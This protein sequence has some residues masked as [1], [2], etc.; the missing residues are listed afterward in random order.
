[1]KRKTAII[2]CSYLVIAA[3]ML[4]LFAS[5][6]Q[7]LAANSERLSRQSGELAFEELCAAS[8]AMST[9]LRK[10]ALCSAP[11]LE[12]TY[13]ADAYAA[14]LAA[15]SAQ[16]ELAFA[17]QELETT[18]LFF[19]RCGDYARSLTRTAASG[20]A[21]SSRD[22]RDLTALAQIA[23]WYADTLE[24]YRCAAADGSCEGDAE[25]ALRKAESEFPNLPALS[26]DGKYA[27]RED[28]YAML[29]GK[30]EIVEREAGIIAAAF[31]GRSSRSADV[32]GVTQEEVP[33]Y[34]IQVGEYSAAVSVQGGQLLRVTGGSGSGEAG[35]DASQAEEAAQEFLTQR[36]YED[37]RLLSHKTENSTWVSEWCAVQDG[38]VLLP[39]RVRLCLSLSDGTLLAFDAT[40]YV[41]YHRERRLEEP[42]TPADEAAA[43]LLPG[44][45]PEESFAALTLSDGG[46]ER[47]CHAFLCPCGQEEHCLV[48]AS[49]ATGA[50]E[51]IIL[52]KEN[53][54]GDL[55]A[56]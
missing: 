9:A 33:C 39:D 52:L 17:S 31:L 27:A 11:G 50:Q 36:G 55:T 47:L 8:E 19:G 32:L 13:C 45:T 12:A 2:V 38:V 56:I 26:Y 42:A 10:A 7:R 48:F 37:M 53:E 22:R 44:L 41:H 23:R 5:L 6:Q 30:S 3:L 21:W 24:S 28:Y 46:E 35:M 54:A 14:S 49:A 16:G 1:M 34:R 4:G 25:A 29:D 18:G 20:G 51:R 43:L 40:D 15:I